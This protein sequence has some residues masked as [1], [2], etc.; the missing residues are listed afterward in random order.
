MTSDQE[1]EMPPAEPI[2][3]KDFRL[4]TKTGNELI[5]T[6]IST[7]D[8]VN[9]PQ[10]IK[11]GLETALRE[12]IAVVVEKSNLSDLIEEDV[13]YN[14]LSLVDVKSIFQSPETRKDPVTDKI[15]HQLEKTMANQVTIMKKL[16]VVDRLESVSIFTTFILVIGEMY[17]VN[18]YFLMM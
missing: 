3:K 8:A 11:E 4:V 6:I 2:V 5:K 12:Y 10:V 18:V 1:N 9:H 13:K 14:F 7:R 17:F 15:G 16:D